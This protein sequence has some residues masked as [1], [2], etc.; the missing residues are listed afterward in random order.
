MVRIADVM[1]NCWSLPLGLLAVV[2]FLSP[3][4]ATAQSERNGGASS[5]GSHQ[6]A[7][8]APPHDAVGA[9]LGS[10]YTVRPGDTLDR[11]IA[12]TQAGSPLSL[13][14]LREAFARINPSALPRGAQG[15]L[16]AGTLL[17][18]PDSAELR[19][20][21]FP[22]PEAQGRNTNPD[23]ASGGSGAQASLL[24]AQREELERRGWVRYP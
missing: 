14:F 23:H 15:P 24:Q 1:P 5:S 9:T 11:I 22:G 21:A 13:A 20:L 2:A 19:R 17:R 8:M 7:A 16:I 12:Q 18:I 4:S 3:A 10:T 6:S